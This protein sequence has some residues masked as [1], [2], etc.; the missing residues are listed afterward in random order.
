M[1]SLPGI[2]NIN[3]T[4]RAFVNVLG[5]ELVF[6]AIN[7]VLAQ[8]NAEVS[9]QLGVFVE[10]DTERFKMRYLLPG[11]GRLQEM[12]RQGA[13]GAVKRAGYYDV[14]FPLRQ[15][16]A[17]LG[18]SRVDM[19]YMSIAEVDA[20]LDT[21]MIQDLNT[22]RWNILTAIFEDT[23]LTFSDMLH[24]DLTV[25]RLANGDGTLYPAVLGS[26]TEAED[27]HYI[28]AGYAVADIA[29]ANNP[30]V[31]LRDEI[32]EHFGGLAVNGNN[33][34]YF[35]GADQTPYLSAI[36]GYI[37]MED[38]FLT[39][40]TYVH[41]AGANY[42]LGWPKPQGWPNVPGRVHGRAWGVW[43]SEW[44]GW[45]PNKYGIAVLLEV[46]APL[47]KRVDPSDTGLGNGLQL[48]ATDYEHP[49][50]RARYEHR[51]G[52][53]AGNR[54]S[55]AVIEINGAGGS[56]DPPTEYAE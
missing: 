56:Y 4:E 28:N 35:H 24:G 16:G 22:M 32:V 2:L 15:Y 6:D 13:A 48:V 12:G 37:P 36:D 5:Q 41:S 34:V 42:P 30:A 40:N 46:P 18:G 25:R 1:S 7:T 27:N 38:K 55:A 19:A 3:D 49:L 26:E 23:N 53:G 45:I 50:Q 43:L 54:L 17:E 44:T 39:A 31:T 33:I 9:A 29:A 14:S 8:Y 11:G 10:R 21:I 47:M 52:L 51:Y 20:H